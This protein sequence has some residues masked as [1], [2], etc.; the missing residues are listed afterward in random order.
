M[1]WSAAELAGRFEA[2]LGDIDPSTKKGQR[3]RAI[4]ATATQMFAEL[5]YRDTNMD[6]LANAVGIGKGTLYLYF[7]K[8]VD[9]LITCIAREKFEWLPRMLE[10]LEGELPAA[11]RLKQWIIAV[12]LL[13]SRS[14]LMRRLLSDT[15]M[16]ALLADYPPA[17]L[18]EA[19]DGYLELLHPLLDELAGPGHRWNA[20]ELRDRANVIQA[21]GYIAPMLRHDALRPG[22]S[23]ERFAAIFADMIVDGIRPRAPLE[24]GQ[25]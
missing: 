2:F 1:G 17:L 20:V 12:L 6:E 4:L 22:M 3:R 24:E 11:E 25:T 8:K 23:E 13:P 5:G 16:T 21:V 15:E 7:P 10:I 18:A 9:L 19:E 14:P